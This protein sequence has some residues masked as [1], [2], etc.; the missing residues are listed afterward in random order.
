MNVDYS[1]VDTRSDE[2]LAK[3]DVLHARMGVRVVC[4]SYGTL[5]V[6]VK[7]GWLSLRKAELMEKRAEPNDLSCT[8]SA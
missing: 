4:A 8:M 5:V 1:I 7:D 3:I 6:A 2:V